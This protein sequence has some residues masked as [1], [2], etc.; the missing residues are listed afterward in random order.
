MVSSW[1][2]IR[3]GSVTDADLRGLEPSIAANGAVLDR[4]AGTEVAGRAAA[5]VG[6]SIEDLCSDDSLPFLSHL[7][8]GYGDLDVVRSR[9]LPRFFDF[10][11]TDRGPG[12][13]AQRDAEGDFHPWQSFA[14]LSLLHRQHPGS[15]AALD[16]DRLREVARHSRELNVDRGEELGH[17]LLAATA[18]FPRPAELRFVFDRRACTFEQLLREALHAQWF[19]DF[20]VCRKFHLTEGICAAAFGRPDLGRYREL[21]GAAFRGQ[22]RVLRVLATL[23]RALTGPAHPGGVDAGLVSRLRSAAAIGGFLAD[24]LFYAGHLLEL[25]NVAR[26]NH[27]P[28]MDRALIVSMVNDM[29]ALLLRY[30]RTP[31]QIITYAVQ[32]CHYR[33]ALMTLLADEPAAAGTPAAGRPVRTA[34][35]SALFVPEPPDLRREIRPEFGTVLRECRRAVP[36]LPFRGTYGHFRRAHRPQWPRSLHYELLDYGDWIGA[37][38]HVESTAARWARPHLRA[39]AAH[40]QNWSPGVLDWDDDWWNGCGRLRIVH[41]PG[42]PPADVA[43]AMATLV[44]LTEDALTGPAR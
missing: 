37:E 16:L 2:P 17:C 23:L 29:N 7:V 8:L 3:P 44:D 40:R 4:A 28:T 1:D 36:H 13:V 11:Q 18:L 21:A 31:E 19:G 41:P 43:R 10:V 24:H 9:L 25:H 15:R 42:S 32:L 14:Y 6:S 22:E 12:H 35:L 27:G 30:L 34:E 20:E 5:L 39:L 38:I 26:Q 33:R